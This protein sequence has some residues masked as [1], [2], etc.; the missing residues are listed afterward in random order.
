VFRPDFL[1][2]STPRSLILSATMTFMSP[3]C[4]LSAEISWVKA[5]CHGRSFP[6]AGNY[7]SYREP[8]SVSKQG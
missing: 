5:A 4:P 1:S 7:P 2:N 3:V 8:A 6:R